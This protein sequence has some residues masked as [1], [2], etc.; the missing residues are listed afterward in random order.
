MWNEQDHPRD[1]DG[2][3]TFKNGG[4][5]SNTKESA[6]SILYKDTKIK[7]QESEYKS[8]LLNILGDKAK[9]TDILY[10]TTKELEEKVKEYGLDTKTTSMSNSADNSKNTWQ[11]PVEYNRISS[12]YGLRYHPIKKRNIFHQGIDLAANANTPVK[13]P[14][15]GTVVSAKWEGAYGNCVRIKHKLENGKEITTVYAHLN[16]FTTANGATLKA[17][18]KIKQGEQIGRVGSTGKDKNGK[19]TSTGNHLHFEVRYNGEPQNP[20]EYFNN[21]K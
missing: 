18:Q 13:A 16:S 5:S 8:K 6:A 17:G 20:H 7:E 1:D 15:D 4:S 2:K 12:P 10:G 9:P 11:K 19:P 14:I 3:F 21:L